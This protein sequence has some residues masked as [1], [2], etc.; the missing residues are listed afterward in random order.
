MSINKIRERYEAEHADLL[1][2]IANE[3]V[4][5]DSEKLSLF[6]SLKEDAEIQVTR[7]SASEEDDDDDF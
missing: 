7:F 4:L 6:K 3:P 1:Q 2:R 5:D